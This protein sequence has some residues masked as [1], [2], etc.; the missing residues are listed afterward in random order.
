MKE[1]KS[2]EDW[3]LARENGGFNAIVVF[4]VTIIGIILGLIGAR[5]VLGP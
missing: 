4:V 2:F 1:R 5:L 3:L